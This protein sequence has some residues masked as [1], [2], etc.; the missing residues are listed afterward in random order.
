[1]WLFFISSLKCFCSLSRLKERLKNPCHG[2]AHYITPEN[3]FA[4]LF[5]KQYCQ[6][7][8]HSGGRINSLKS[9]FDIREFLSEVE[10][11]WNIKSD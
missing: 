7:T 3:G 6:D 5:Q 8:A 10:D 11:K 9:A 4:C 2:P 1:M